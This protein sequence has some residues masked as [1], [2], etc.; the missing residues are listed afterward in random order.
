VIGRG[1]PLFRI[2]GIEVGIH[3]SW[4]II[5][6]LVTWSL[7]VGFFPGQIED[8]PVAEAWILGA[9]ASL[10]LFASVLVHELAHAFMA[11]R[12]GLEAKSIT[13]FLFGGVAN[14]G[15]D[16]KKPS[17]E[18]LVAV[19]GPLTSFA[20]AGVSG[21]AALALGLDT[22]AG[23]VAAYLGAVN[24][25]LAVFNLI[26]G[27]PL[28]GGRLLRALVWQFTGSLRRATQVAG[29][30]GQVFAWGLMFWGFLRL[31]QG[32]LIF[33]IWTVA[34]GWFLNSAASMSVQQVI[35]D[36]RL[37]G[38]RVR[39]VLRAD[40][41]SVSPGH[42]VAELID[43][44][45]LPGNRRAVPVVDGRLVGIV[46][47]GDVRAVPPERRGTTRVAEVMSGMSREGPG[48]VTVRPDDTLLSALE[49]LGSGDFEQVPVVDRGELLGLLT[50][51]DI[52][53]AIQVRELVEAEE[54]SKDRRSILRP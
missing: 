2:F 53:R 5:F 25:L 9:I 39:D 8:L 1:V 42:S 18:F 38:I 35:V 13:L 17:T 15:G 6:G 14:L 33:G 30:V 20:I 12:E 52:V 10:L 3:F 51:A 16:A 11:R 46:T 37:S 43:L 26:P 7:A 24:A 21:A 41:S 29:F 22:R 47:L 23:L 31:L 28:D 49:A 50:R 54:E 36:Q 48:L 45:M 44:V 40:R 34:I 32:D 19:V 4:L 27:F